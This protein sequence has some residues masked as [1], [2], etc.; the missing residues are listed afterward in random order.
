M[1][2]VPPSLF[3]LTIVGFTLISAMPSWALPPFERPVL[4]ADSNERGF[5]LDDMLDGKLL[6]IARHPLT[7][8]ALSQIGTTVHQAPQRG[9]QFELL[10]P[11]DIGATMHFRW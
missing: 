11:G 3:L 6:A 5:T 8:T 1:K 2:V 4:H 9:I 7:P 10:T